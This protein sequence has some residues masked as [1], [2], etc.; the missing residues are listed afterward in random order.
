M[1]DARRKH[2]AERELLR[3]TLS[4]DKSK[5]IDLLRGEVEDRNL[6]YSLY[7]LDRPEYDFIRNEPD[8]RG[9]LNLATS[10][11]ESQLVKIR[12]MDATGELPAPVDFIVDRYCELDGDIALARIM[13]EAP[14]CQ[15]RCNDKNSDGSCQHS[16]RPY[17]IPGN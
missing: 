11:L 13:L 16:C 8:F 2:P 5:T 9:L 4:G 7:F 12:K 10:E 14:V 3:D 1:L 15:G 17:D 6:P